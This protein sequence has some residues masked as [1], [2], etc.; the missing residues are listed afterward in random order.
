MSPAEALTASLGGRWYAGERYGAC[1]C[2]VHDDRNPSLSIRD[3]DKGVL[4]KCH[5]GCDG[6]TVIDELK[7][8]GWWG[9]P[10]ARA[11]PRRTP[12]RSKEESRRYVLDMWRSCGPIAGTPAE[13]YLRHRGITIDLPVSLRYHAGLKHTDTGLL[14]PCMVAAVQAQDRSMTGLHRTFLRKDGTGKAGVVNPR[15]WLGNCRGGAVRLAAA[16]SV[17]ALSEGLETGLSYMQLTGTA[18]WCALSSDGLKVVQIPESVIV[19]DILVDLDP[20]G[21]QA[22]QVS[23]ERFT[24][25]G[26]HVNLV[27]PN[28]G[29]DLN[30]ALRESLK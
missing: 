25:E 9:D 16:Q 17:L 10:P 18:T 15:K 7:R 2:P 29:N 8:R 27:R 1:R 21:E 20:A 14:L 3:G 6:Q 12:Q 4:I 11:E 13:S 28:T 26:R 23:G 22:A 19:V 24:R 5:A 30:D